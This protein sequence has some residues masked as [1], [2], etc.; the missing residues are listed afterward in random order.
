MKRLYSILS[1]VAVAA[2]LWA[3]GPA[4]L[5]NYVTYELETLCMVNKSRIEPEFSDSTFMFV[6]NVDEF[7]LKT[8]DRVVLK[9]TATYDLYS[10]TEPL[11]T[12]LDVK[13]R[14]P[15]YPLSAEIDTAAY[16]T[17]IVALEPVDFFNQFA[18][19]T[20]VWKNKQN[21]NV[22]YNG[23]EETASFAMTVRGVKDGYVELNLYV[24][25]DEQEKST[26]TLLTFDISDIKDFLTPEQVAQLPEGEVVKT[27]IYPMRMKNGKPDNSS[28]YDGNWILK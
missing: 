22:V 24:D 20:W 13:K 27:R 23:V 19:L 4:V 17:P 16:K 28:D 26:T 7:G 25:A 21:I 9:M 15:V 1:A 2:V 18:A 6:K 5:E 3:C 12:I 8:G 14:I 10:E 11:W